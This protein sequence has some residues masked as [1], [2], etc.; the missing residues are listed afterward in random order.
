MDAPD[1][2]PANP[3]KY[4][5]YFKPIPEDPRELHEIA[6]LFA[7]GNAVVGFVVQ[8]VEI[9]YAFDRL[10]QRLFGLISVGGSASIRFVESATG[11][12]VEIA[13]AMAA[14]L[15]SRRKGTIDVRHKPDAVE[16]IQQRLTMS[17]RA[18]AVPE[19][20]RQQHVGTAR[21]S[22]FYIEPYV[23]AIIQVHGKWGGAPYP[24]IITV[25]HTT[26]AKRP[27]TVGVRVIYPPGQ[28]RE[29]GRGFDSIP[30]Y[31]PGS[32]GGPKPSRYAVWGPMDVWR[33]KQEQPETEEAATDERADDAA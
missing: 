7:G 21:K 22:P 24:G 20:V 17:E 8:G 4:L 15:I 6:A 11:D 2:T 29:Q 26:K 14:D 5:R 19:P 23:G 27:E 33:A 12:E 28:E 13:R 32:K 1:N 25:V 9:N 18:E 3:A 10:G 30:L 16:T 31:H